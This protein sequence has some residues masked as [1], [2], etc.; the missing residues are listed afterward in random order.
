MKQRKLIFLSSSIGILIGVLGL[1]IGLYFWEGGLAKIFKSQS[2]LYSART[3]ITGQRDET[4]I[5]GF[6]NALLDVAKKVSGDHTITAI[7]IES[8]AHGNVKLYVEAFHDRDRMEE[9][10]IH[11]EQGTR[12]RSFELFVDFVPRKVN[13]LLKVL[14]KQPWQDRRPKILV[15]LSVRNATGEYILVDDEDDA[16]GAEQRA[17]FINSAWQAGLPLILPN[18]QLL[19]KAKINGSNID[20]ISREQISELKQDAGADEVVGGNLI[21]IGGANGWNADWTLRDKSAVHKWQI[22]NTN[23]DGA[24][25]NAMRGAAQI[26]SGHGEPPPNLN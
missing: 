17:A 8:I 13:A 19:E 6:L 25:R 24:F 10:P 2:G 4:R 20:Q 5:L 23:F 21:W 7:Q 3:I 14:G 15:M 11:D 16:R 9:I 18:P 26:L 12:D 22:Q 1:A